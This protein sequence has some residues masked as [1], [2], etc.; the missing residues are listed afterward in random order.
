M[1]DIWNKVGIESS[2]GSCKAGEKF[3]GRIFFFFF[4]R[5]GYISIYHKLDILPMV[6]I[7]SIFEIKIV[8]K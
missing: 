3:S 7:Q 6:G 4:L 8:I 5:N 1:S 2:I